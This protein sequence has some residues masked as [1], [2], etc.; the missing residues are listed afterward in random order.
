MY[1]RLL[2]SFVFSGRQGYKNMN[3]KKTNGK[4]TRKERKRKKRK[5]K[6]EEGK[7]EKEID[8]VSFSYR[9]KL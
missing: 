8:S 7:R 4:K 2:L 6:R 1:G 3:R 5:K 9:G